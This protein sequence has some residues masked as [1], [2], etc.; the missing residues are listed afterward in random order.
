MKEKFRQRVNNEKGI[1]RETRQDV[2]WNS[3]GTIQPQSAFAL[4]LHTKSVFKLFGC[5]Y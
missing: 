4:F 1:V 5:H 2:F 3:M